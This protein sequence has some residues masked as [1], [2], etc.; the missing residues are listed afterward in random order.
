M[1]LVFEAPIADKA[2]LVA[3]LEADPY[4]KTS[5]SR[6]GYKVKDGSAV[7]QDKEKIYVFLRASGEFAA[8]AKEKLTGIAVES[9]H[10]VA[11]AIAKKIE[12]EESNAEMGFGAIFG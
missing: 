7:G 9:K 10:D 8:F 6:N 5:F 1:N 3:L 12:D 11:S 4:A 2:K